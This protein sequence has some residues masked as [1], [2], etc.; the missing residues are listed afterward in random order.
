LQRGLRE[1]GLAEG[2]AKECLGDAFVY[3]FLRTALENASSYG[4]VW[5]FLKAFVLTYLRSGYEC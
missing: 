3:G 2:F 5:L 4:E 1:S